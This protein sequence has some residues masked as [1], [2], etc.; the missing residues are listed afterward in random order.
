MHIV[1][2]THEYPK[3]GINGGGIGSV[4]QFL[5]RQ[6]VLKGVRVSIIG[7]NNSHSNQNDNDQGVQ[8]YRLAKS[9][10]KFAKFYDNKRRVLEKIEKLNSVEKIDI[11]E[12]S[13]L[14]FAFFPSAAS[15]KK[16]IRLHGGH[17]F[18][19]IELGKKPALWRGFQEKRS[20]KIGD[21][22]IAVSNYVGE[23]T[24]KYLHYNFNYSTIYNSVDTEKFKQKDVSTVKIIV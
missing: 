14:N 11:V 12:G 17:H 2:L 15:Y 7:M 9:T 1:Y 21:G 3:K 5:G 10:W 24:Q 4:V 19:A 18:Y 23:Q 20:F 22:F 6:L 8:I 16:I 13:E